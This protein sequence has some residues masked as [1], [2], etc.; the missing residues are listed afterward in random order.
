MNGEGKLSE[1]STLSGVHRC[2]ATAIRDANHRA[3][4]NFDCKPAACSLRHV[5]SHPCHRLHPVDVRCCQQ[6]L[7]PIA[8]TTAVLDSTETTL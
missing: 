8:L 7:Q 5:D 3:H 6:H 1:G 2:G 4:C